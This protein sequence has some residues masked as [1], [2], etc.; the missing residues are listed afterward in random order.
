MLAANGA[1]IAGTLEPWQEKAIQEFAGAETEKLAKVEAEVSKLNPDDR[2]LAV[3]AASS[4]L[5]AKFANLDNIVRSSPLTPQQKAY[6]MGVAVSRLAVLAQSAGL[7]DNVR[8]HLAEANVLRLLAQG[9]DVAPTN[10][11]QQAYSPDEVPPVLVPR[12]F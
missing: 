11:R 3:F 2:A 12:S 8:C 7:T 1:V 6:V 5:N 9:Q 10:C 4:Y